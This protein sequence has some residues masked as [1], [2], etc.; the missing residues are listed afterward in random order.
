MQN[1]H[2]KTISLALMLL[3]GSWG[4]KQFFVS[5]AVFG[6]GG[7]MDEAV[8]DADLTSDWYDETREDRVEKA[9]EMADKDPNMEDIR[10]L[11]DDINDV[12]EDIFEED[13]VIEDF[14]DARIDEKAGLASALNWTQWFLR[15]KMLLDLVNFNKL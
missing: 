3:V 6:A 12:R 5:M 9:L 15:L 10:K 14:V 8:L 7:A 2:L 11:D 4:V 1:P 13:E